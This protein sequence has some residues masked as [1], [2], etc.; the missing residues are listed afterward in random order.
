MVSVTTTAVSRLC[1]W[2]AFAIA[3]CLSAC[4]LGFS[5]DEPLVGPYSLIA[6]DTAEDISIC[7]KE[8]KGATGRIPATVVA[9]GYD[10]HYIVAQQ[11]P[12]NDPARTNFYYLHIGKDEVTG[13]LTVGEFA[14]KQAELSL[15]DFNRPIKTFR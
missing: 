2:C 9:V 11:R 10:Q 12:H 1:C 4:N 3:L 14:V 15:P 6:V 5:R 7:R 13:P 8:G